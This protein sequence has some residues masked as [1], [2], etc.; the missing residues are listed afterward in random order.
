MFWKWV[1][2]L[3]SSQW[4]YG[5]TDTLFGPLGRDQCMTV[6]LPQGPTQMEFLGTLPIF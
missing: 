3:S 1:L 6:T 4:E 2:F 5:A